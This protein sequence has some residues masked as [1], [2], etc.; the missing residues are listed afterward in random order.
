[1]SYHFVYVLYVGCA[2]FRNI[3]VVVVVVV[4]Q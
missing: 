1:M 2:L 3:V 4:K